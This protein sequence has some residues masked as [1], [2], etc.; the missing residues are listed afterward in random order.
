MINDNTR[1]NSIDLFKF[2]AALL[3]VAIHTEPFRD[4]ND[5]VNFVFSQILCRSA[6]PF[7]AICTGYFLPVPSKQ[8]NTQGG[9]FGKQNRK[10]LDQDD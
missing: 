2:V 1:T 7:F 3:V 5:T 9:V 8:I 10:E 6:V 4:I